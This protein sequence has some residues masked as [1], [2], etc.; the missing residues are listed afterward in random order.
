MELI[1]LKIN[2]RLKELNNEV[3]RK[4]PYEILEILTIDLKE[5]KEK[6]L[7]RKYGFSY[8]ELYNSGYHEDF[9]FL[10]KTMIGG[11]EYY[12]SIGFYSIRIANNCSYRDR[13]ENLSYELLFPCDIFSFEDA[14]I[15]YIDLIERGEAGYE[16]LDF[17][18]FSKIQKSLKLLNPID[19]IFIGN[20]SK[21]NI[22]AIEVKLSNETEIMW[23]C[24]TA[25]ENKEYEKL[26]VLNVPYVF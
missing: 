8:V 18:R 23:I 3:L 4:F 6:L 12:A 20:T 16:Y 9:P 15:V 13:N 10:V 7:L 5:I 19:Y 2:R 22:P 1:I 26:K 14:S 17:M 21:H 24:V 11:K 25:L